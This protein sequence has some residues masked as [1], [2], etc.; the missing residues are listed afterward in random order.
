MKKIITVALLLLST[1]AFCQIK[2]VETIPIE[3]LGRLS[4][5]IFIQ[6]EGA[7]YTIFYLNTE[8]G[9]T[10]DNYKSIKFKDIDGDYNNLYKIIADGF[11]ASPLYDIKLDLPNDYVWL[12]FIAGSDKVSVQFMTTNKTTASN[13]I[14]S[15]FT[16][17]DINKLFQ[18]S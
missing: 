2:V 14:S 13:G 11:A 8:E 5:K 4:N 16:I 7:E 9:R 17:E 1:F 3:K 15:S 10:S 6:K 12:H 18:K